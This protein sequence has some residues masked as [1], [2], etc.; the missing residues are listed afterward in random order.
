MRKKKINCKHGLDAKQEVTARR[1]SKKIEDVD[2]ETISLYR[3]LYKEY[4]LAPKESFESYLKRKDA[5]YY[6]AFIRAA[7]RIGKFEIYKYIQ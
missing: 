6:S 4:F 7:D 5:V 1:L 2:T 3:G